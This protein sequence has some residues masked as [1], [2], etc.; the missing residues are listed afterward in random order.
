MR[1]R[2]QK[3]TVT[4]SCA[5]TASQTCTGT[6]AVKA[7]EHL[8]GRRI[9][10]I[11]AR[12]RRKTRTV[13]LATARYNVKGGARETLTRTLDR[14][15]KRLLSR[16]HPLRAKVGLTPTGKRTTVAT[17]NVIFR[18]TIRRPRR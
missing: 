11:T 9:T 1:I 15:G 3:I 10:A 14:T 12:A 16:Y 7:L 5:G 4:V 2:G 17:K 18:R 13:T 6:L 8:T